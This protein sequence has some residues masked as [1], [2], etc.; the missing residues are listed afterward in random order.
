MLSTTQ[1]KSR[2]YFTAVTNPI[3]EATIVADERNDKSDK[4]IANA[5]FQKCDDANANG[6]KFPR[7]VLEKAISQLGPDLG[8]RHLLGELDH[9]DDISDVNRI[10]TVSLKQASHVITN[11]QMDGDYIIGTFETLS[12]P[13]GMILASLL[14]DKCKIGVSVRAITDQDIS[15]GMDNVDEINE[16]TLITYD[17]VHN[18][19]YADAYVKS[20]KDGS[21]TANKTYAEYVNSIISSCYQISDT[22]YNAKIRNEQI[23]LSKSELRNIIETAL[24]NRLI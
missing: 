7:R 16:F 15:Y 19:A 11:L 24:H 20:I 13:N 4:I 3:V 18:P 1:P 22:K 6:H 5:I 2:Y 17:A 10:A 14:R 21:V 8:E 12:T 9:P 23:T